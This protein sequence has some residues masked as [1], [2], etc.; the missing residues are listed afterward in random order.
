MSG[1]LCVSR[2][3]QS[4][5][6]KRSPNWMASSAM[7][8]CHAIGGRAHSAVMYFSDSQIK[9]GA[10]SSLGKWPLLRIVLRTRLCSD[11]MALVV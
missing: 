1:I 7:T 5:T 2:F 11:S 4:V 10:D 9:F 3:D 8:P 6:L